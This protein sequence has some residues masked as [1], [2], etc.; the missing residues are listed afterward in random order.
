M[1]SSFIKCASLGK[2]AWW[3][4][5]LCVLIPVIVILL[6][7]IIVRQ[8]LPAVKPLFPD[9]DFGKSLFTYVLIIVIFG[10]SLVAFLISANRLH[11]R[12]VHSLV[13]TDEKF[14]WK[15]YLLGFIAWGGILF[16]SLLVTESAQFETFLMN[17]DPYHFVVLF[18]L[19]F[20]AIGIQSF[21]EEIVLRGYFLQGLHLR[22]KNVV[23][24][25]L[26]NALIFAILHF[27]YGVESF[28]NSWTFGIAFAAIVILQNR[29]EFVS[30]AHNANNLLLALAFLDL[31]KAANKD[32]SW[33]IDWSSFG[34]HLV[35]LL[36]LVGFVYL[37]LKK[38]K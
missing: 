36:L 30:G 34:L 19:G 6:L 25:V 12:P 21:F 32:F 1:K 3:R 8:A 2:N 13:S 5:V 10:C 26:I 14:S 23:W 17:F 18:F 35:A 27:G 38:K 31:S 15:L 7:N 22:V 33:W 16:L 9:N 20:L 24:L 28:L 4:Y 11:K 37:F 29:I